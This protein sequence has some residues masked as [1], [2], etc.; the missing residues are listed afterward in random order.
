MSDVAYTV[1][2]SNAGSGPFRARKL[3]PIGVASLWVGGSANWTFRSL[4]DE[5]SGQLRPRSDND[6]AD[7]LIVGIAAYLMN[8]AGVRT[9][10]EKDGNSDTP[11]TEIVPSARDVVASAT[12]LT[13]VTETDASNLVRQLSAY[14]IDTD[15]AVPTAP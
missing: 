14:G 8:D 12:R 2:V 7:T 1:L 10:L 15:I 4:V 13:I 11:L 6:E 5:N 3:K 9:A